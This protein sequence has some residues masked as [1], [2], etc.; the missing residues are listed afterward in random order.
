MK[1]QLPPSS[2]LSSQPMANSYWQKIRL[3][4]IILTFSGVLAVLI[5]SLLLPYPQKKNTSEN[6]IYPENVPIVNWQ[7]TG[8][9]FLKNNAKNSEGKKHLYEYNQGNNQVKIQGQYQQYSDSN[10]SRFLMIETGIPPANTLPQMRYKEG[11]GYY[12]LLENEGKTFLTACLNPKGESTVTQD[13]HTKNRYLKTMG[14]QRT[15]LWIIGQQDL[16]DGRCLWTLISIPT[17]EDPNPITLENEN[18]EKTYK[19]L[20]EVW[21]SW[22]KWWKQN[23]PDY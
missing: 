18:L 17:P 16:T 8:S 6:F 11:F 3:L 13:Q 20:E 10:M 23:L 4:L 21:F 1:T 15:L 19:Q 9:K 22:Y 2:L 7:Q 5:R 14:F 12:Y